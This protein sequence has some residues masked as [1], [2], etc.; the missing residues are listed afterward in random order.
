MSSASTIGQN[1]A[2]GAVIWYRLGEKPR[3]EVAL[4]ILDAA[5]KSIR[6]FT[7]SS[8]NDGAPGQNAEAAEGGGGRFGGGVPRLSA[9]KGLNRF[10]WDLRYPDASRFP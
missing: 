1:P 6:R 5:G 10:V 2:A 8:T 7:S 9:E 3:G 4:E